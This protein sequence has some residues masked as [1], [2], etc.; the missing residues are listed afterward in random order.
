M[1]AYLLSSGYIVIKND[2]LS[3]KKPIALSWASSLTI[4]MPKDYVTS[5]YSVCPRLY[6]KWFGSVKKKRSGDFL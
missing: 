4:I 2:K 6:L 5:L 1:H 3:G